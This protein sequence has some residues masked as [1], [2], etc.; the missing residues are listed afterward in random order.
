VALIRALYIVDIDEKSLRERDARGEGRW[1]WSRDR[2]ALLVNRLNDDYNV[3]L[4]GF[5]VIF[6]ERDESS[7][8][9]TMDLL[10]KSE[11][12][13]DAGFQAQYSRIKPLLDLDNQFANSFKIDW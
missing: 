13:N 5:D 1:P 4:T 6:S 11:L 7:G 10:A 2:L 9:R 3:S 12:K 8:I